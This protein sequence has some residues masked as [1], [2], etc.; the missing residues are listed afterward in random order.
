MKPITAIAALALV[1]S[2]T[3][4]PARAADTAAAAGGPVVEACKKDV[5]TLCPGVQPGDGRIAACMKEH[6][7]KLSDGCK[8]A[9]K[10]QRGAAKGAKPAA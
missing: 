2:S 7:R 10:A 4:A 1:I 5:E 3:W 9:L 6:R 8:T